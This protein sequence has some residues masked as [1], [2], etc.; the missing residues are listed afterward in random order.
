[1][2]VTHLNFRILKEEMH[3]KVK[4]IIP[5]SLGF[6]SCLYGS[7]HSVSRCKLFLNI[8]SDRCC[9]TVDYV[10]Q[11]FWCSK[12]DQTVVHDHELYTNIIEQSDC[13]PK[14]NLD[15]DFVHLV[16]MFFKLLFDESSEEVQLSCVGTL[17]RILVHGR[18]DVL[19]QMKTNWLKCVEFL[20][21]NRKK[22][23][24]EAFCL[25]ISS[26][27]EDHITSC[28]FSEEDISNKRKEVMFLDFIKNA[29]VSTADPQILDTILES[30]AEL[31]NAVD[32]HSDFFSLSL[33][34]L[35]DHLDNPHITV[36]LSAS[37]AIHRA[38][39]FHFNGNFDMIFSKVI[40]LRNELFDH[41]SSRLVNHPKIVQEFAEAVL[42]VE[43][44]VFVKKMIPVVLPKL[45]VSHQNNDQAVESLY[46]LAKCVDTDMVTL[47]VNWLPK[48]LAFVLYQANGKE[49]CSAL[50]FYHAQT[51][52]TQEE[53]FAAALP[54][55]LDE[56]VCFVDG[57]NSDEV[58][59]RYVLCSI[60]PL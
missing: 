25:Q 24:R 51:G 33:L 9:Q 16:S 57:G 48:V 34:L 7:C 27:L 21:L 54:A 11:G 20:L 32:I 3:E 38:C 41:V 14:M 1:M 6:L 4:K 10:L 30:V 42:G 39:C 18:R 26:F 43:T 40:H 37:R 12:C 45:I 5:V 22:S 58:S 49:L 46:E 52:S 36:R 56:L 50:E 2:F 47:I 15:S 29:M 28:F 60:K 55:L 59:K 31:M 53:I 19:H 17:R 23:I 13:Y 8:N 35:V 44:E